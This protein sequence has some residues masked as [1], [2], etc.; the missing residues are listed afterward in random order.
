MSEE[1]RE[2][3]KDDDFSAEVEAAEKRLVAATETATAAEQ[4]AIA[5]VKSLEAEL[6]G[7][8]QRSAEA[9]EALRREHAKELQGEREARQRAIADA[10]QRLAEIEAQAEA[11]ERRVAAAQSSPAPAASSS[12]DAETRAREAAA[13][14][15]RG[16][17]EAIRREA[18]GR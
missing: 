18:A 8:R 9:L 12:P 11:A 13:A 3:G 16:Q 2:P 17:I 15:L 7:E 6:E 5:E 1:K 10:E 4:R 14:W